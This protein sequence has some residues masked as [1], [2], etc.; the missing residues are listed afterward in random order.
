MEIANYVDKVCYNIAPDP[1]YCLTAWSFIYHLPVVRSLAH[2]VKCKI[3]T[4]AECMRMVESTSLCII[5]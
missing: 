1:Y 4:V 3:M 2:D 5:Y